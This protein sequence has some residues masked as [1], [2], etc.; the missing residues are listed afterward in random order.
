MPTFALPLERAAR[1]FTRLPS[2]DGGDRVVRAIR[3]HPQ[4]LA[5]P[6]AA[7]A[8]LPVALDGWVGKGGAEGLFAPCRETA[9]VSRSRSRTVSSARS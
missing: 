4:L 9:W 7:D 2:L 8:L 6:D 3:A 1:A 5:G